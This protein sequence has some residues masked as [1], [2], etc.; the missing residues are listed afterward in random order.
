MKNIHKVIALAGLL[1]LLTFSS[2]LGQSDRQTI[3]SIPFD[4]TVAEKTFP[5]GK[6]VIERNKQD[7][8]T[9]WI[10][11]RADNVAKAMVLT[12]PVRA[13]ETEDTRLVFHRY[14]DQYF[15]SQFWLAGESTGRVLEINNRER[16][17]DKSLAEKR[18]NYVLIESGR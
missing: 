10:I 11:R 7:S 18:Q 3:V 4:F 17:L 1:V 9:V 16:A 8:N 14:G 5:A 15:L 6:Y 12:T 2:A 13:N